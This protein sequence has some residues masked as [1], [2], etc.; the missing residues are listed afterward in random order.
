MSI[1]KPVVN[2]KY[3][4]TEVYEKVRKKLAEIAQTDGSTMTYV[5]VAN[6]M[7]IN[8]RNPNIG[9]IIGTI[10]GAISEDEDNLGRPM[11]SALVVNK[12]GRLAGRPSKGFYELAEKLGKLGRGSSE[13]AQL[14][15][16]EE[17]CRYVYSFYKPLRR[18]PVSRTPV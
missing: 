12:A 13:T 15:F 10:V 16:W 14:Q 9:S 2:S 18:T 1:I 4:G 8:P 5:D 17:E 3:R 6:V 7:G 11:L